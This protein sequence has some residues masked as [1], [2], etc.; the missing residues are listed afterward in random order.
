MKKLLTA[1]C[2][3]ILVLS[4]TQLHAQIPP[5][6]QLETDWYLD[7]T[8]FQARVQ[9]AGEDS[10]VITISNGLIRRTFH[11]SPNAATVGFDNLMTG[12]AMLRSV[13]PEG[14]VTL[15]GIEYEIGGLSGQ[16]NHAFLTPEWLGNL[17]ANPRAMQF[18]GLTV[19]QPQARLKW[20]QVRHHAPDA[21]W[22]PKGVYLRMDYEMPE[23]TDADLDTQLLEGTMI[24]VGTD[25]YVPGL[26]PASDLGRDP[27]F[28]DDFKTLDAGWT[29]HRSRSHVRSSF[30]NEGKVGEI[31][32][33]AN[34]STYAEREL[35]EGTRCVE[36]KLDVGTDTSSSWGPAIALVFETKVV[37]FQLRPGG[38]A[39]RQLPM[40]G[41]FDGKSER[42]TGG[43]RVKLDTSK[44]WTLRMR[45]T[46]QAILFD[47]RPEGGNWLNYDRIPHSNE[48]GE[49]L[50]VRIGK[51]DVQGNGNDHSDVGDLVRLRI[52]EFAAWSELNLSGLDAFRKTWKEQQS[53]GVSVHYE[54]Y[55]AIPV[56]SKWLTVENKSSQTITVD[57][58]TAEVLAVVEYENR[59]ESRDGVPLLAPTGLHVETDMAF[60]GFN[61]RN[62]NRHTVN[63]RPD[64]LFSSQ[65]NYLRQQ[66][67]LLEVEP[68][69]G[70]AQDIAPGE[71]FETFRVFE[72]AYDSEDRERRGLALRKM[73]RTIAPWVT[74][75]PLMLH[76]RSS[77]EKVVRQAIDQAA[78]TGFE[79]VILSFGSGFNA[80][81]DSAE[82]LAHWKTINN[83]AT[84]KGIELG[85]YSLYSSRSGGHGNDI[86]PPP[87]YENAHGRCPAITSPWGQ[88]YIKKLYNLFDKTGFLVFENDGPYPG[89]VD[90]TP[91]P[92]LQKGVEDSRWV[93]WKIWSDFYKHLR[94]RGVYMNLPDYYYLSGSNKCGMG[95]REV[96]WS[97]PRE[98]Q[99]VHT[100]QNIYD[101]TWEKT[102][103]MG[104]M[105]VPLTQYHGG[106]AAATIEPL[107]QHL[108]H[109]ELMMRS[110]LGLGVQACYRGMRLYDTAKTQSMVTDVVT[111]YKKHRDILE[112]D[113]IHGRR[114][115]GRD[116]DWMLHVNPKL[117]ER[118]FLSAYNP[119]D[120]PI[121]KTMMVPL[122][123]SGLSESA[124]GSEN[125]AP[126]Q[127]IKLDINRRAKVVLSV[128]PQGYSYVVFRKE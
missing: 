33:P 25:N 68:T 2:V 54:M 37:K 19:G 6:Y 60:G 38:N 4:F 128:P 7:P 114:A 61:H 58:F 73:Y 50:K 45:V 125:G 119:T 56:I 75:N 28:Q 77:D 79:M 34:T 12:E 51:M 124:L 123:Y 31:Y 105:F 21:Q 78:E 91:R 18:V 83:Y 71:S 85:S 23:I 115:D 80:E 99:R 11:K 106:G 10:G 59:V 74:E 64:P 111:W 102:P 93:H 94:E 100:R 16:P 48:L 110:N 96:N 109:Y 32:T 13:R 24:G 104:W 108:D 46:D 26:A 43:G 29:V 107:E 41:S 62:A 30:S 121:E 82:Y 95:Y 44:P 14:Y 118:A 3:P 90:V 103:S 89:D 66:P 88:T 116:V 92:P 69:F 39:Y 49:P 127:E 81:N 55:D 72:L 47:G 126:P 98:E 112:S 113:V 27:L 70:P 63:W 67:C 65:V 122:Y 8:P 22:P 84:S 5:N 87:G 120:E 97:L 1:F 20:N 101:G 117:N 53:V 42:Q 15:N 9:G 35:P 86:V 57:R 36:V 76:C 17:K 52:M 40:L